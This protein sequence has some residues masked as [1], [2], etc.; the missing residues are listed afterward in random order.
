MAKRVGKKKAYVLAVVMIFAFVLAAATVTV[1]AVVLRYQRQAKKNID[2]LQEEVNPS[3]FLFE[4]RESVCCE[5]TFEPQE[6]GELSA[7]IYR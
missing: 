2:N 4:K 7:W 3:V 6:N 1:F 5:S